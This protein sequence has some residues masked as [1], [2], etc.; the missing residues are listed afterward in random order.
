MKLTFKSPE[1]VARAVKDLPVPRKL[2]NSYPLHSLSNNIPRTSPE[3]CSELPYHLRNKAFFDADMTNP[4]SG[5]GKSSVHGFHLVLWP[6]GD[7]CGI[8]H[9]LIT[10]RV[11][12]PGMDDKDLDGFVGRFRETDSDITREE[13]DEVVRHFPGGV[14]YFEFFNVYRTDYAVIYKN[15]LLMTTR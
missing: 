4:L 8:V 7:L 1:I 11:S 9:R 12:F 10:V 6:E 3:F 14:E 15:Q 2:D 13:L 5:P